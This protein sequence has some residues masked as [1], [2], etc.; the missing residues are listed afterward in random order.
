M[1]NVFDQLC[2]NYSCARSCNKW[3]MRFFLGMLD[4]A[5]VNSCILYNFI[6]AN[7]IKNKKEYLKDLSFSLIKPHLEERV[8]KPGL[9]K[10]IISNLKNILSSDITTNPMLGSNKLE[11]RK[12]CNICTGDKVKKTFLLCEVQKTGLRRS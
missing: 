7:K 3:S 11:K 10:H 6:P 9:N 4:Q 1:Q 5:S 8:Q 2:G 12:R